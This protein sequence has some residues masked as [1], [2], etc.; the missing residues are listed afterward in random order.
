MKVSSETVE[1]YIDLLE[2][3]F[4]IFRLSGFSRNLRK[5]IRKQDK[6]YFYDL[7]I[8]N[9]IINNFSVLEDRTDKGQLWENF[10]ISERIK[11]KNYK[12]VIQTN[13]FLENLYRCRT[14]LY[15]RI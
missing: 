12:R 8:R 11:Q 9:S 5:E 3:S 1:R 6:I 14:R 7:G 4:I 10:L 2:K 13:L 15:R